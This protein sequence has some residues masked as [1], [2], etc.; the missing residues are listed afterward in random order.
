MLVLVFIGIVIAIRKGGN[1]VGV[2]IFTTLQFLFITF[3]GKYEKNHCDLYLIEWMSSKDENNRV[4]VIV[5]EEMIENVF[6]SNKI[7]YYEH[8]NY[9]IYIQK[10]SYNNFYGR[11]RIYTSFYEDTNIDKCK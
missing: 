2:A 1:W 6:K 7:E 8:M 5:K 10:E 11:E 3:N 4:D 9:P